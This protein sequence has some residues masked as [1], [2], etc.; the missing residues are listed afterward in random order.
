MRVHRVRV[1]W[2][3]A[4]AWVLTGLGGCGGE[5]V[6]G[7]ADDPGPGAAEDGS[8]APLAEG[9]AGPDP[10]GDPEGGLDG[11]GGS[12]ADAPGPED[13]ADPD[14]PGPDTGEADAGGGGGEPV[15]A[16]AGAADAGAA[17]SG[18][19][20][21]GAGFDDRP[22]RWRVPPSGLE[23]GFFAA[24][25][26]LGARGWTTLDLNGD[27][28]PDLVQTADPGDDAGRVL[29]DGAGPFWR[30]HLAAEGGFAPTATRW[31]VPDSGLSDGFFAAFYGNDARWW[32]TV[33]LDGDR[34]PELVQTANPAR[35]GGFVR[36][37]TAGAFWQVWR[38]GPD[39]FAGAPVRW[40]VPASGLGD[41]FFAPWMGLDARQWAL[42]DTD[43]DQ[44][45]DLVQTSDPTRPGGQVWRDASGPHWKVWRATAS[46][47]EAA[48]RRF[49][50]PD[51][52]TTDGFF[53]AQY[54]SAAPGTRFWSLLDLDGDRRAELV[55]TADPALTGGA[56]WRDA[57]GPL[58]RVYAMGAD[59]FGAGRVIRVGDS[60]LPDGFFA[61]SYVSSPAQGGARFWTSLDLDGDGRAELVQ[62]ADPEQPGGFAFQ[63]ARGP[64]WKVWRVGQGAEA[65]RWSVPSSGLLDGFFTAFWTDAPSGARAWFLGDLDGD[66]RL[67]LVQTADPAYDGLRVPTDAEG[68][69]WLVFRGR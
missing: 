21:P 46:G 66:T 64:F 62:T 31:A 57:E 1:G 55:H 67:D 24:S 12:E 60:G 35:A 41:G 39:G 8:G 9:D 3:S 53:A 37:D 28:R 33:D 52:G 56:V 38:S 27:G 45:L 20:A 51:A 68:A 10:D 61:A 34:R 49:G 5:T 54:T 16:D 25:Q 32:Y 65:T 15:A 26:L 50:V 36:T 43:G 58:W 47:F 11:G 44:R 17:D 42:V 30:V 63:D 14:A 13:A 18:S 6:G 22:V 48:S 69:F 59:G 29:R 4:A 2:V 7:S 19:N 40:S 23:D